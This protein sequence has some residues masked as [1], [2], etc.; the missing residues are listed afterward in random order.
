VVHD[1]PQ[2]FL[3]PIDFVR[4]MTMAIFR[5]PDFVRLPNRDRPPAKHGSRRLGRVQKLA[6]F[7]GVTCP[8][9][10]RFRK[11]AIPVCRAVA[12]RPVSSTAPCRESA[13]IMLVSV[14]VRAVVA[15]NATEITSEQISPMAVYLHCL[16]SLGLRCRSLSGAPVR[17]DLLPPT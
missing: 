2:Q 13:A 1:A 6:R 4:E 16:R 8:A 14:L 10:D 3:T 5:P 12:G 9:Q 17:R 7:R 11:T 15:P